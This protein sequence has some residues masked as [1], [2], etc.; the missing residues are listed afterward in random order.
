MTTRE[1]IILACREVARMDNWISELDQRRQYAVARF[2]P[3]EVS[4]AKAR[5]DRQLE[6]LRALLGGS[7]LKEAA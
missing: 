4:I 3:A 6:H 1:G 2:D 7:L 5:I